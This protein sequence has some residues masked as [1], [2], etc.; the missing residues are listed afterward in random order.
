M[1]PWQKTKA[2]N[3]AKH[4]CNVTGSC[5]HLR[6]KAKLLGGDIGACTLIFMPKVA[7]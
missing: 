7:P 3:E 1:P 6:E 2:R 4:I 5:G